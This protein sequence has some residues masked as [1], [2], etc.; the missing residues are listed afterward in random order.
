[1]EVFFKDLLAKHAETIEKLNVNFNNGFGDLIAKI[2]TL[3][4]DQKAVIEGDIPRRNADF[5]TIALS[6]EMS[7]IF[8]GF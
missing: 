4:A 8:E 5:S 3:P 1:M 6:N 2:E 7:L